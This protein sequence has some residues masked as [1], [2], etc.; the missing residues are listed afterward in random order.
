MDSYTL[1]PEAAR[2]IQQLVREQVRRETRPN[3]ERSSD[4]QPIYIAKTGGSGIPAMTTADGVDTPGTADVTIYRIN[5]DDE[6]EE[7]T[8]SSGDTVT[9]TAYN[10]AS[11][12][13]AGDTMIHL[14]QEIVSGKLLADFEDCG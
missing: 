5:D 6:L 12:A 8:N 1:S 13:V 3:Y 2:Q 14:K 4:I 10:L 7:A 11:S 9:V